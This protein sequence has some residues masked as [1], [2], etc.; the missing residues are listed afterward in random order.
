MPMN[1]DYNRR[2]RVVELL[3]R[4]GLGGVLLRAPANFAY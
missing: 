3:E 1:A 2:E 4:L